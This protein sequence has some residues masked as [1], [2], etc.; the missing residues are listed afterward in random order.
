MADQTCNPSIITQALGITATGPRTVIVPADP[1]IWDDATSYEYL[2]L[3]TSA[4]FGQGYVS[5]RDVPSGTPL[6]NTDYWIPVAQFNAQL[7][8]IQRQLATKASQE[9][10]D[11][12][13]TQLEAKASTEDLTALKE[14][15][16]ESIAAIGT[17]SG[18]VD[19]TKGF[20]QDSEKAVMLPGVG[21]AYAAAPNLHGF[22]SILS[23]WGN[24]SLKLGYDNI[25]TFKYIDTGSGYE[26]YMPTDHMN[27]GYLPI[28]CATFT[29]LVANNIAGTSSPYSGSPYLYSQGAKM[30][31]Y[32]SPTVIPYWSFMGGNAGRMLTWQYAKYL[33]DR[34]LLTKKNFAVKPGM[35][36]FFGNTTNHPDTYMGI[37]HCAVV[38]NHFSSSITGGD[39]EWWIVDCGG[40]STSPTKNTFA[41][42]K[43]TS[44]QLSDIVAGYFPAA[45]GMSQNNGDAF[46]YLIKTNETWSSVR[47]MG[48]I[49][50]LF[51]TSAS[52][53]TFNYKSSYG[54]D[55]DS[56]K[57]GIDVTLT[58]PAFRGFQIVR[59]GS[60]V[61]ITISGSYGS[62]LRIMGD[63]RPGL[64]SLANENEFTGN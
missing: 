54:N 41:E 42:R 49:D 59:C 7:A 35:H 47:Q 53:I 27:N 11:G 62:G 10:V 55:V 60:T 24:S 29:E 37:Y 51:N 44:A 58:L 15:L 48:G 22:A 4:D 13:V 25:N 40:I 1:I 45:Y 6:T 23:T 33:E 39:E 26:P 57:G 50:N 19:N 30:F 8:E 31:D 9:Q 52:P 28:D 56:N 12:I 32:L 5:K 64:S 36:I 61:S 14:S 46:N 16:E 43:I 21:G 2:T 63:S 3:V 34:G 18:V 20:V 17:V 38:T